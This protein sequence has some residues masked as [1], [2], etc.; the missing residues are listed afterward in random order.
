M[1]PIVYNVSMAV[2]LTQVAGGVFLVWGFGPSL[3]VGGASLIA[4]TVFGVFLGT[5][6]VNRGPR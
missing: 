1:R 2:G 5:K 6:T 4:M 3:I